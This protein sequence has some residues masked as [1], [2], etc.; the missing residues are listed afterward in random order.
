LSWEKYLKIPN[1]LSVSR[2]EVEQI[3]LSYP[4]CSV[5]DIGAGYGRI[6]KLLKQKGFK[7]TSIDNSEKMVARLQDEGLEAYLMDAQDLKFPSNNFQFVVSD[8]LFEHFED[9]LPLIKEEARVTCMWAVNFV[10]RK[11]LLNTILEKI[12]RVPKEYR[13][14]EE[15]WYSLHRKVFPKVNITKLSR[16]LVIK[17]EK[18]S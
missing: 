14:S 18:L 4:M 9:P 10:P 17:C 16:L 1:F 13:R 8:G 3:L 12:Q 2:R 5:L 6:T 15:E 7:V 11:L